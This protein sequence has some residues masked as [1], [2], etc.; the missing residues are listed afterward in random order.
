MKSEIIKNLSVDTSK[1]YQTPERIDRRA[2]Q[3]DADSTDTELETPI[4][5]NA[6][7]FFSAGFGSFFSM[8]GS[9]SLWGTPKKETRSLPPKLFSDLSSDTE[10][11]LVEEDIEE[12]SEVKE[13]LKKIK[14]YAKRWSSRAAVKKYDSSEDSLPPF[15]LK[16][17]DFLEQ[18]LPFHKHP[19]Y[20]AAP[21]KI[22]KEILTS[23]WIIYNKK[24]IAIETDVVS[25]ACV[26][27]INGK[28]PGLTDRH[29]K[30][31][32]SES[33][34]DES[35]HTTLVLEA[36]GI[37]EEQRNIFV[38][39]P[40]FSLVRNLKKEQDQYSDP[41]KKML[42]L[43]AT[44]IVSEIFISDYLKLISESTTIQ[45]INQRV[46]AA[47][48]ADELTHSKIFKTFAKALYL[49]LNL[50]EKAFFAEVLSKPIYWFADKE[51]DAWEKVL[52]GMGFVGSKQLI[53]DC[54]KEDPY[55][56]GYIDYTE[57]ES[58]ADELGIENFRETLH[59]KE[60]TQEIE[61]EV[62]R[63]TL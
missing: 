44:A 33:M 1:S 42:V 40:S 53:S 31:L 5:K 45:K 25:P 24:T 54:K 21:D 15:D 55:H 6:P 12:H 11:S 39:F 17:D 34:T 51:L 9:S 30:K 22:K 58:L 4:E 52:D 61:P 13:L 59:R 56:L 10:E 47:H 50:E 36:I 32:A 37:T 3:I 27:I 28:V 14:G 2:S 57:L 38:E 29:S 16:A 18:L 63:F 62:F 20:L 48:R 60:V 8:S 35:F 43:L 41:R 19:L 26:D 7:G 49:G 23:A 46:V